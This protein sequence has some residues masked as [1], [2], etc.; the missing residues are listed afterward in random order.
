MTAKPPRT[1][2]GPTSAWVV[3]SAGRVYIDLVDSED[4]TR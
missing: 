2:L 1:T 4:P 3:A